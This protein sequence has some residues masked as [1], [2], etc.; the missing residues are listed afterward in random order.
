MVRSQISQWQVSIMGVSV[1]NVPL[2][3]RWDDWY[4]NHEPICKGDQVGR[5]TDIS[6][7][8]SRTVW[9]IHWKITRRD[10]SLCSNSVNIPGK[11]SYLSVWIHVFSLTAPSSFTEVSYE[12]RLNLPRDWEP[13]VDMHYFHPNCP[14]ENVFSLI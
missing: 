10:V 8:Y 9:G 14:F 1:K 12:F 5:V 2:H 13:C 11:F 7:P 3:S 4:Q 6:M